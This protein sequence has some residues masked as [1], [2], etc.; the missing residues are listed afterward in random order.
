MS[1][2]RKERGIFKDFGVR[3]DPKLAVPMTKVAI[4][5]GLREQKVGPLA[6]DS[7]ARRAMRKM[8]DREGLSL[9]V[10]RD[11][12]ASKHGA[13]QLMLAA[14][15]SRKIWVKYPLEWVPVLKEIKRRSKGAMHLSDV[16]REAIE[17]YC[18]PLLRAWDRE[19]RAA[20]VNAD[21]DAEIGS[22]ANAQA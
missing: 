16:W 13:E 9:A 10:T 4:E 22:L 20:E 15:D 18:M 1:V 12:M 2:R 3:M 7:L 14:G 17:A 19:R 5:L 6:L 21:L 11:D 8:A